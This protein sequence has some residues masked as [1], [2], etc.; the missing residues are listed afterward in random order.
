MAQDPHR[1]GKPPQVTEINASR[2]PH[3][4]IPGPDAR[5]TEPPPQAMPM[6]PPKHLAG[7]RPHLESHRD[8]TTQIGLAP[9]AERRPEPVNPP[10][11]ESMRPPMP[12][13][14]TGTVTVARGKWTLSVPSAVVLA[15]L[16]CVGGAATAWVNKSPADDPT[17]ALKAM[18]DIADQLKEDR[19]TELEALTKRVGDTE[20]E[21]K[22]L[23]LSV[24]QLNNRVTDK[25]NQIYPAAPDSRAAPM[26]D[27]LRK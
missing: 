27:L 18:R 24:Q 11:P 1:R 17:P 20:G 26:N 19:K 22:L 14:E 23:N 16:T 5:P 13:V 21:L 8:E 15:A 25:L 3:T 7:P 9:P 4:P 2:G 6:R 10:P 12:S